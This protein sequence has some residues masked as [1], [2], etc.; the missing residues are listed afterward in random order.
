MNNILDKFFDDLD[1]TLE[2]AKPVKNMN[3]VT[4]GAGYYEE[5]VAASV[6]LDV[7]LELYLKCPEWQFDTLVGAVLG[8]ERPKEE[9]PA[10]TISDAK[11]GMECP[12]GEDVK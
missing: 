8:V 2:A 9:A 11:D 6:K 3:T 5:L 10:A 1:K 4:I 7:L 12:I